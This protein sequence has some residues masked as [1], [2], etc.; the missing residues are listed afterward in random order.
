MS[1]VCARVYGDKVVMA[2]DSIVCRGDMKR[3]NGNIVK[4]REVNGMGVG[5]VGMAQELNLMFRFAETHLPSSPTES[6]MQD[7]VVEFSK[8]KHGYDG[9]Y[10]VENDYLITYRGRL[11]SIEGFLV[12]EVKEYEAIGAGMYYGEAALYLGHSPREAVKVSCDLCCY[13]AEPIV[14]IEFTREEV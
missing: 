9:D 1:V 14:E 5:G 11:F 2:A 8:Q 12:Y 13:V 4:L 7:F 10:G 6:G 3:T